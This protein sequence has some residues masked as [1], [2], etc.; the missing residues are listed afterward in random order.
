MGGYNCGNF[1]TGIAHTE[2][3]VLFADGSNWNGE[4]KFKTATFATSQSFFS[5]RD[6]STWYSMFFYILTN[7]DLFLYISESGSTAFE[8]I[9]ISTL[10][11]NTH[12]D[13]NIT[14]NNGV[15]DWVINGVSGS[16]TFATF[17]S[18]WNGE[19]FT[20]IGGIRSGTATFNI[21]QGQ[22]YKAKIG[23]CDFNLSEGGGSILYNNSTG[24]NAQLTGVVLSTFWGT[25][26]DVYSYNFVNGCDRWSH[27]T[28][29]DVYVQIG[30]TVTESGYTFAETIQPL[31]FGNS[32]W[33]F[34]VPY[35]SDLKIRDI[36]DKLFSGVTP[37]PVDYADLVADDFGHYVEYDSGYKNFTVRYK[38]KG[39]DFGLQAS[40]GSYLLDEFGH[41]LIGG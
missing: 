34:K 32:D 37:I 1:S 15:V 36:N 10:A 19:T 22:L 29:D 8:N 41:I 40:D 21:F 14:F 11:I 12:Y 20:G 30:K 18:C 28:L 13:L 38:I 7:G 17:T 4:F 5:H 27:A 25:K 3:Q 2:H 16:A 26:Q 6:T 24:L 39:S 9:K 31:L 35:N 33:W 23:Y